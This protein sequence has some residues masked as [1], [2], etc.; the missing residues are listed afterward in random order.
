MSFPKA[1]PQHI[2]ASRLFPAMIWIWTTTKEDK[3]MWSACSC[4]VDKKKKASTGNMTSSF[5]RKPAFTLYVALLTMSVS[6]MAPAGRFLWQNNP[7]RQEQ[8]KPYEQS[9]SLPSPS[10]TAATNLLLE[11]EPFVPTSLPPLVIHNVTEALEMLMNQYSLEINK[12]ERPK[13][14]PPNLLRTTSK[15]LDSSSAHATLT[16][17]NN[18]PTILSDFIDETTWQVKVPVHDQLDFAIIAHAKTGT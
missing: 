14:S 15:R 7:R 3:K 4:L 2:C 12:D 18:T 10:P 16:T 17:S 9:A 8:E 13:K 6:Y 1:R 11:K 5:K